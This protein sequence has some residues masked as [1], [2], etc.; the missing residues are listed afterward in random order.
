MPAAYSSL[1]MPLS[2]TFFTQPLIALQVSSTF[3]QQV[4][5]MV[6]IVW[7]LNK[8]YRESKLGIPSTLGRQVVASWRKLLPQ[9]SLIFSPVASPVAPGCRQKTAGLGFCETKSTPDSTFLSLSLSLD[10]DT[11]VHLQSHAPD[12]PVQFLF[13]NSA[14]G[15]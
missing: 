3:H 10:D 12:R 14:H 6:I 4:Q 9:F 1:T 5:N 13:G 7:N 2:L 15:T 8:V 11:L